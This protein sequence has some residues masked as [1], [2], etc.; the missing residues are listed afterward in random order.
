MV[1]LVSCSYFNKET[2]VDTRKPIAKVNT[3]FLYKE[4][5]KDI[6][7]ENYKPKDSALLV[8]N[9]INSW[10][11]KQLLLSKARLNLTDDALELEKLVQKYR[12]DLLI[13]KYREAVITQNLDT[14]VNEAD[15]DTFYVHNKDILKL[16]EDLLKLKFIQVDKNI[17]DRKKIEKLFKSDNREDIAI[18]I[19]KELEFKSFY[20]NDS[21]WIKYTDVH[22]KIPLLEKKE[23]NNIKKNTY[24]VKEDSLNLYLINIK[25]VLKRNSISPK[26]YVLPTIKQMILHTRKL[27]LLKEIETTLLNDANKNGQYEIYK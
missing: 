23:I 4:D 3:A 19:D 25:E 1:N 13:N 9:Y 8:A 21:I 14:I 6:L 16:N 17:I 2:K 7:P 10:A 5:I 20:F 15:I 18:L 24:L 11:K 12:E 22:N 26:S 27:N